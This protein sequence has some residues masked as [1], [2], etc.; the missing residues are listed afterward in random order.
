M[1]ASR[2]CAL[3]ALLPSLL[4]AQRVSAG[5]EAGV[6]VSPHSEDYGQGCL[7]QGTTDCGPNDFLIKPY[8][9]G[10]TA[11]VYL[12]S[13][14]SVQAGFL[15]Q[16]FH[17]D[18][19]EGLIAHAGYLNFGQQYGAAANGWLFPLLLKYAFGRR[20]LAPFVDAGATLRHLGPFE[21]R[22]I[23]LDFYLNPQPTSVHFESGRNLD[24]AI[25]GGAGLEWRISVFD[26]APEIR[27][28]HWTSTYYQPAQNQAML[29][30]GVTFPARR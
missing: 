11:E 15:Y 23:Q 29:M 6:P 19:T 8:A 9:I 27:F 25:T 21:G 5:V 22:G 18:V 13:N 28:L 3:A 20:R 2:V 26:V 17:K 30:L 1:N 7:F 4:P 24:V 16:R 12:F 10:A 14:I